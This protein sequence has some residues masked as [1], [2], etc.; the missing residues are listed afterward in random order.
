MKAKD[1]QQLIAEMI[2]R[3]GRASV[4]DLAARLSVSPETIRRDLTS[5]DDAGAVKKVHGGATRLGIRKEGSFSERVEENAAAKKLIADKLFDIVAD[6]ATIMIDAGSTTLA[7]AEVMAVTKSLTVVTNSVRVATLFS[8]RGR[9][10]VLLLGGRFVADNAETLG[11]MTIRQLRDFHADYALLSPAAIDGE[12][13]MTDANFGEASV[14]RAMTEQAD[15]LIVVADQSKF[16]KRAAHL[17][18]GLE[19]IDVLVCDAPPQGP[20]LQ[21]LQSCNVSVL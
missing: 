2:S 7:C 10:E 21:R 9:H 5:L 16:E 13:G 12:V 11:E 14:A 1:R 4:E 19:G 18:S 15:Q 3:E 6:G 20:L 8:E 17:V